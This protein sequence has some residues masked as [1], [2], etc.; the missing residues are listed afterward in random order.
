MFILGCYSK[1]NLPWWTEYSFI[2]SLQ[3]FVEEVM[4]FK[5]KLFINLLINSFYLQN[6]WKYVKHEFN[7][8]SSWKSLLNEYKKLSGIREYLFWKYDQELF[9]TMYMHERALVI[10]TFQNE[11]V[12]SIVLDSLDTGNKLT[13]K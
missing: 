5:R 6:G 10:Q 8:T 1:I 2:Q 12:K 7:E 11:K 9:E 3:F 13:S 4:N